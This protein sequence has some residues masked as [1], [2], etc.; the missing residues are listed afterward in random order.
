ML[1]VLTYIHTCLLNP[2]VLYQSHSALRRVNSKYSAVLDKQSTSRYLLYMPQR[3]SIYLFLC[4]PKKSTLHSTQLHMILSPQPAPR[5]DISDATE[6]GV[7]L[8]TLYDL[9][10][11][12]FFFLF[13]FSLVCFPPHVRYVC[14]ARGGGCT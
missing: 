6:G 2:R 8:E 14:S 7:S 12:F 13:F 1:Q 5:L 4:F 10:F 9:F 3:S 11:F